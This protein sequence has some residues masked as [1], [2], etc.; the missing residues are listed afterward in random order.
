MRYSVGLPVDHVDAAAEF[1]TGDAIAEMAEA[2]E[3][4]GLDAVFVT[5]HPAPDDR[6]LAG[7]GH[8]AQEPLVALSFAAA[9]TRRVMLHTHVY[10]AAYRN[11]FLAAKGIGTLQNLSGGRVLLGVAAGYLWPEFA[12][13]GVDFERRN[14]LLA[15]SVAVM[16]TVWAEDGVALATDDY[17][18]RG[19]TQLPHPAPVP[20]WIGG[21]STRAM[22]SAAE[23]GDGWSP[24][25]NPPAA[26]RATKT[27][28]ITNVDELAARLA[29][30]R[31]YADEIGRTAP[32]TICFSRFAD[33]DDES[34]Y[35]DLG[36]DWLTVGFAGCR[37]RAEW[38]DRLG[39]FA[40]RL[41]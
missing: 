39:E 26:S 32:L 24:F 22:R 16:R 1:V 27:P 5:D 12:A 19:V 18:A 36:I 17:S 6:W 8:H 38:L 4:A 34:V 13:L 25:P 41:H 21:N 23:F 20:I 11:P 33:T 29:T 28:A 7:G 15:D 37:T 2:V 3:A 14:E 35:A 31:A 10:V 40:A 9:A 30:V